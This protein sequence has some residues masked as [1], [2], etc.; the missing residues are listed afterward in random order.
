MSET[1]EFPPV[2]PWVDVG[3]ERIYG[4]H[5]RDLEPK[6]LEH[7]EITP[8]AL[9]H[10]TRHLVSLSPDARTH[11]VQLKRTDTA[12]THAIDDGFLDAQLA[13]AGSKFHG[14]LQ[15]PRAVIDWGLGR[16]AQAL[17]EGC[18]LPWVE[19]LTTG[20]RSVALVI[21]A[22]E[23]D[24][25][26]LGIPPGEAMGNGSVIPVTPELAPRVVKEQRGKGEAIDRIVVNVITGM[27]APTTD[28]TIIVLKQ[29]KGSDVVEFYT[30]FTGVSS[31]KLPRAD[32]QLPDE[33]AYNQAWWNRHTFVKP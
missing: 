1:H 30:A 3:G 9:L 14:T 5:V 16:F 28:Q 11:L 22:T 20:E 18:T 26:T 32:E 12:G 29:V 24:K 19:S 31:P 7:V 2:T 13:A 27:D 15:D 4:T 21:T 17:R 8:D 23:D 6:D 10:V 33:L 25:R